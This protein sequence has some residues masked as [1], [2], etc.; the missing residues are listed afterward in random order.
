MCIAAVI[1]YFFGEV[2]VAMVGMNNTLFI[3][4]SLLWPLNIPWSH[5]PVSR[6]YMPVATML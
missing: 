3:V 6:C 5:L 1:Q 4:I 2:H